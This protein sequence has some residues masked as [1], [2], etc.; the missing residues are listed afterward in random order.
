MAAERQRVDVREARARAA[1][2]ELLVGEQQ[3]FVRDT[4][5]RQ[6]PSICVS[7]PIYSY[8]SAHLFVGADGRISAPIYSRAP[9]SSSSSS[10][11][12]RFGIQPRVG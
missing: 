11:S 8:I 2:L 9:L 1:E 3:V 5:P 12:S 7:A 4:N 10:A 6:R